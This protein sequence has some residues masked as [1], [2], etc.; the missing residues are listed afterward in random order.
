MMSTPDR[1]LSEETAHVIFIRTLH[2][3]SYLK[4][5]G[6]AHLDIRCVPS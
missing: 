3:L 4:L 2:A 5:L 6:I 1:C